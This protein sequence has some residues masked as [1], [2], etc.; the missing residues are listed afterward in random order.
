MPLPISSF[1]PPYPVSPSPFFHKVS[2]TFKHTHSQT[3]PHCLPL[4]S[5]SRCSSL[6]LAWGLT[7]SRLQRGSKQQA[8]LRENYIIDRSSLKTKQTCIHLLRK[9]TSVSQQLFAEHYWSAEN[10]CHSERRQYGYFIH[11]QYSLV[12]NTDL[13]NEYKDSEMVDQLLGVGDGSNRLLNCIRV[14]LSLIKM[15]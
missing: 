6:A 9:Q 10:L 7:P 5:L 8:Y 12:E 3:P 1:P 15:K 4:C 13:V 14:K 11:P 2:P